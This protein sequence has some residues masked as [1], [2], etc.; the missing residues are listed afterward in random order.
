[1]NNEPV[2]SFGVAL[3][4]LSKDLLA[5]DQLAAVGLLQAPGNLTPEFSHRARCR[6]SHS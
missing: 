2:A 3:A 6:S 4:Q 5:V 1:L